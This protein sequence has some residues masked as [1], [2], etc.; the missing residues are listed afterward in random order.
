MAINE[1]RG[2]QNLHTIDYRLHYFVVV[3]R[4]LMFVNLVRRML[5]DFNSRSGSMKFS[6]CGA[7]RCTNV[8]C[9]RS[10][11]GASEY[12]CAF[13][14]TSHFDLIWS[15]ESRFRLQKSRGAGTALASGFRLIGLRRTTTDSAESVVQ[16]QTALTFYQVRSTIGPNRVFVIVKNVVYSRACVG[17]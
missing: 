1:W 16:I 10:G 9:C 12:L 8:S 17:H 13:R 2:C 15:R 3:L 7:T 11:N 5:A 14:E 4:Q 6:N